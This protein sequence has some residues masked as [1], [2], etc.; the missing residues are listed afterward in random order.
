MLHVLCWI[1][2]SFIVY[3]ADRLKQER[4][5]EKRLTCHNNGIC[6]I[7][8]PYWWDQHITSLAATL[9]QRR[10]DIPLP[11]HVLVSLKNNHSTSID[12]LAIPDIEPNLAH[13]Q[14]LAQQNPAA[15]FL[16]VLTFADNFSPRGLYVMYCGVC[17]GGVWDCQCG[18]G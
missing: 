6:L 2:H 15:V 8:V 4:D 5:R 9:H 13:K 12:A 17:N 16:K 11:E 7:E 3:P 14:H 1:I 10:Q 18:C